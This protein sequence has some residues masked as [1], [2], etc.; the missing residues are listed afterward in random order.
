MS[1]FNEQLLLT[2]A[3]FTHNFGGFLGRDMWVKIFNHPDIQDK[4]GIK[5]LMLT[6]EFLYDFERVYTIVMKHSSYD[7]QE[8]HALGKALG[9]A[10][11]DL[12]D[13][14]VN[15]IRPR[16]GNIVLPN[17]SNV[18]KFV[19]LFS[20]SGERKGLF[21]TV[22]QDLF[23]ERI[24]NNRS[25]GGSF[26]ENFYQNS[27][28]E[29]AESDS[30]FLPKEG[31]INKAD[32]DLDGMTGLVYIKLHGS[33]GWV[34]AE[35]KN[36]MVIGNNK[37]EYINQEPLLKWNSNLFQEAI[38]E[39]DKKLLIIGYS[40]RDSYITNML[41]DGVR[42]YGLTLYIIDLANLN[43]LRSKLQPQILFQSIRGYFPYKLEVI[44]P[45]DGSE[46]TQYRE[47]KRSLGL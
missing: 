11:K 32:S 18:Q 15:N 37:S 38:K 4:P 36:A 7:E 46:T 34:S 13:T 17:L 3:G 47:I 10:Y 27:F 24:M 33:F 23:I 40:F 2:G 44:F 28:R 16:I 14:V 29:F 30:I 12:D 20:G 8:R 31:E 42:N 9:D 25:P 35:Q 5:F 22:N 43:K 1:K 6:G 41:L 39:G 26:N 45:P 21:F 19:G